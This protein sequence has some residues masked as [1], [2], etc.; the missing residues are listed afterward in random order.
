[1]RIEDNPDVQYINPAKIRFLFELSDGECHKKFTGI[2]SLD[3]WV[4]FGVPKGDGDASVHHC[5]NIFSSIRK[6]GFIFAVDLIK[7]RCGHYSFND[8]Q[9]RV[10]IAK[11]RQL[12]VPAVVYEDKAEDCEYCRRSGRLEYSE[13]W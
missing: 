7:N 1:M 9:H 13:I 11:R 3:R 8:G 6:N 12:E 2:C 5:R 10:C 4:T